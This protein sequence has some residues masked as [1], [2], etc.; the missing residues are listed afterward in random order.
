MYFF[1]RDPFYRL[2]IYLRKNELLEIERFYLDKSRKL[3][4][5]VKLV[6]KVLYFIDL[7]NNISLYNIIYYLLKIILSSFI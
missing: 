5:S 1:Y 3:Y 6:N 4:F 7:R 2:N